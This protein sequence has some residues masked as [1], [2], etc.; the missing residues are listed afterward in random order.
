ML[1]S[2]LAWLS[3]G[4]RGGFCVWLFLGPWSVE[5]E[6]QLQHRP[7]QPERPGARVRRRRVLRAPH[8]THLLL[9]LAA[10]PCLRSAVRSAP[11]RARRCA[12]P[13]VFDGAPIRAG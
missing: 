7:H 13:G 4:T 9:A 6:Y 10:L 1:V 8:P 12:P 2:I 11:P 5:F 3:N